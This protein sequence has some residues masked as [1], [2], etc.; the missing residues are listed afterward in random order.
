MSSV[1]VSLKPNRAVAGTL[2]LAAVVILVDQV[3]ILAA[4]IYPLA[5]DS[6]N[7]R[8]GAIGLAA[9]RATPFLI[10]DLLLLAAGFLAGHRGF[11]R[12]L[13][14]AHVLMAVLLLGGLGMFSL[15]TLEIRQLLPLDARTSAL[16]SAGRAAIALLALTIYCLV[17]AVR[18]IRATPL[19]PATRSAER[20]IVLEGHTGVAE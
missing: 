1:P 18:V 16:S 9:G 12:V 19:R 8:F 7:W 4:S 2:Y 13:A 20:R 15:D 5:P 17:V 3:A 6:V 10:G 14:V 11:L